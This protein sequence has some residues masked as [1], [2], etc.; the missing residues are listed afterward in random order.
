MSH[1]LTPAY[2]N[3]LERLLSTITPR[4]EVLNRLNSTVMYKY[5]LEN[6]IVYTTAVQRSN[7]DVFM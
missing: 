2:I 5:L 7:V 3:S 1:R 6:S 4:P